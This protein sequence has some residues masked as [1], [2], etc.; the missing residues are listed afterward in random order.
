M[1]IARVVRAGLM[2]SVLFL[3]ACGGG[4][5]APDRPVPP[6]PTQRLQGG[7]VTVEYQAA[8]AAWAPIVHAEG[9]E[10]RQRGERFF[11]VP[12][13]GELVILVLPDR[14]ALTAQWQARW[15]GFRP[16][17]WMI[18]SGDATSVLMLSPRAWAQ[19]S[20]GHDGADAVHRARVTWHEVAHVH[21]AQQ[22]QAWATAATQ[23]IGW[24]VE[25]LAVHVSGQLEDG[26][27]AFVQAR[28]AAGDGPT[29][30]ADVLPRGYDFA[31]SLVASIDRR[32]G[33]AAL[34]AL[35]PEARQE[36]ILERLGVTE[37]QLLDG[38]RAD[39]RDGR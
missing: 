28:L 10:G 26:G 23:E 7:G 3:S 18:A 30:L 36:R 25:G 4:P 22:N 16:E 24:Y 6:T 27:G 13:R 35:L 33:R 8:D 31:G 17:C 1:T 38:W 11:G 34:L 19:D 32:H 2:L 39:A 21:H 37:A 14:A 20:C 12:L 9:V 15:G 5:S 29:R